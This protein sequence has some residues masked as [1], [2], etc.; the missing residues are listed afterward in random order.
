MVHLVAEIVDGGPA[1]SA[2]L[3]VG[4]VITAIDGN[5]IASFDQLSTQVTGHQAGDKIRITRDCTT[6][7]RGFAFASVPGSTRWPVCTFRVVTI[8]S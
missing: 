8:P 2:G 6:T 3:Q 4:D 5:T 7:S 1:A